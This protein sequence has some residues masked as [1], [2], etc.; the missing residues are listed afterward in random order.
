MVTTVNR[1]FHAERLAVN[2][3]P[4]SVVVAAISPSVN[5]N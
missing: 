4:D 5:L 1:Q 3:H 2:L